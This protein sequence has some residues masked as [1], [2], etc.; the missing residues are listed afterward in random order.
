LAGLFVEPELRFMRKKEQQWAFGA[1]ILALGISL[2]AWQ[3][4]P[5]V[6]PAAAASG[7]FAPT[8]HSN[9]RNARELYELLQLEEVPFPE[10]F[11][12]VAVTESG[13][14]LDSEVARYNYNYFGFIHPNE[15]WSYSIGEQLGHA[16]Y[17]NARVAVWDLKLWI[18]LDPPASGENPY[19]YLARRG[20]NPNPQY[21]AYVAA[22]N[23][24][25]GEPT[26]CPLVQAGG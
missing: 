6:A 10:L 1:L 7:T 24:C 11:T 3:G 19:H 26:L 12:Q 23:L 5:A 13:W 4:T 21:Y 17:P 8:F 20:Y 2:F 18:A 25:A 9:P 16:H 22:I 15:R 14:Q